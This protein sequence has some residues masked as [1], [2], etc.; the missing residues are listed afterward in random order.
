LIQE[1]LNMDAEERLGFEGVLEHP[2]VVRHTEKS[3]KS[4]V[5]SLGRMLEQAT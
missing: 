3:K 5:R 4:G 2:W 1:L